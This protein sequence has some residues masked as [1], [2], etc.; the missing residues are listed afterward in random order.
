MSLSERTPLATNSQ[1]LSL[2]INKID[3]TRFPKRK[4]NRLKEFDY[5]KGY[6]YFYN[7]LHKNREKTLS[8]L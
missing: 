8:K 4:A 6:A 1:A 2:L 3:E 7:D 5:S